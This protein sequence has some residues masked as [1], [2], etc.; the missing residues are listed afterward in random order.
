MV[1]Q[2]VAPEAGVW[3]HA[4]PGHGL[5]FDGGDLPRFRSFVSAGGLERVARTAPPRSSEDP[6][7]VAEVA[8]LG[9]EA[10]AWLLPWE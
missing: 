7:V 2:E 10:L 1:R 6:Y 4:C 8:Y 5:W 3:V 9:L